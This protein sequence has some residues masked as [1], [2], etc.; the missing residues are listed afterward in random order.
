MPSAS[1]A[2]ANVAPDRIVSEGTSN[3]APQSCAN[4]SP[5]HEPHRPREWGRLGDALDEYIA[6]M[7]ERLRIRDERIKQ[8]EKLLEAFV[9]E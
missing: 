1:S 8:L 4:I 7:N 6:T 9:A 2:L 5:I 3:V